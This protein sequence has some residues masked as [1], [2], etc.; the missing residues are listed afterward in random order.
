MRAAVLG[1]VEWV[2]FVRVDRLPTAGEIARATDAW[3]GPAGGGAVAAA[4]L[5]KLAGGAVLYTA[6]GDDD[7]GRGAPALLEAEGVRVAAAWRTEATRRAVTFVDGGGERTIT[8][9]GPRLEPR[10]GDPLPWDELPAKDAVYVCAADPAA[11]RLA[12]RARVVVASS[13]IIVPA[14]AEAG[15]ALDAIV[16][17]ARDPSEVYRDGDLDPPPRLV[18]RT[19]GAGGGT[20]REDGGREE[21]YDAAPAPGPLVDTYG[22]G[23]SFAA[24]LAF[25]LADGRGTVD[26]IAFAA[27]CGAAVATGRGPYA[28]QLNA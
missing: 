5:A 14:L 3:E 28:A 21:R 13:R 1:H 24:G 26:A 11:I 12:R 8:V 15:V 10:A 18:V 16:G 7:R 25:A 2:E 22:C 20:Y 17:S 23:D 4:Q 9:I 19:E 6:L 27:R